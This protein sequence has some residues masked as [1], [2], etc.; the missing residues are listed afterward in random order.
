[1]FYYTIVNIDCDNE[2]FYWTKISTDQLIQSIIQNYLTDEI[3]TAKNLQVLI[4]RLMSKNTNIHYMIQ[5]EDDDT[6]QLAIQTLFSNYLDLYNKLDETGCYN[7][8]L[9]DYPKFITYYEDRWYE[10]YCYRY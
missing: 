9:H 4:I 3:V 5:S 6:S 2:P 1:M 10:K 7:Y 8:T